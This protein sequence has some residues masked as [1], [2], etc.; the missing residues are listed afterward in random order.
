MKKD[1]ILHNEPIFNIAYYYKDALESQEDNG[2]IWVGF[3]TRS[4]IG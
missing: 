3:H 1:G 2:P 4:A